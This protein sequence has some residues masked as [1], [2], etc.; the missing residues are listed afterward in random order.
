MSMTNQR[1][2]GDIAADVAALEEIDRKAAALDRER[3]K[4]ADERR[5]LTNKRRRV[6]D[7][8][9]KRNQAEGQAA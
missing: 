5:D 1:R 6:A 8:L 4:L 2:R 7:R 3:A 9:R